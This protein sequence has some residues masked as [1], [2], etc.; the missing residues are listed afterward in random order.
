MNAELQHYQQFFDAFHRELRDLLAGLPPEA[1]N[2]RPLE[3]GDDHAANSLAV[4][5]TH[6]LGAEQFWVAEVFG[7]RAMNRDRAAE[8]RTV[9]SD[10]AALLAKIEMAEQLIR[11][12]LATT[13]AERL[14]ENVAVR[15][16]ERT[17]RWAVIHAL[18][19]T[20]LHLGHMEIT[21]QL[22]LARALR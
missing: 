19:H 1:L 4:I 21:R 15:D 3:H 6:A 10:A 7:G 14:E 5:L 2:W 12:V 20:A 8:F 11:E 13:P 18:E 16:E 22:W 9:V 17:R